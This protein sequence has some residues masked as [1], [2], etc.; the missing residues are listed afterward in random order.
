MAVRIRLKLLGRKKKPFFRVVAIDSK[1]RR[2][3]A[4]LER[5]GWYDPLKT[6]NSFNLKEDRIKHWIAVGAVTSHAVKGVFKKAGLS[7]KWHL[8]K[9]GKSENE[10]E[11][12]LEDWRQRKSKLKTKSVEIPVEEDSTDDEFSEEIKDESIE[13][14]ADEGAVSE[15]ETEEKSE[16]EE[17]IVEKSS[18]E[19]PAED[20]S[21][22]NSS[23]S[24][25]SDSDENPADETSTDND[26][27]EGEK[28]ETVE[29]TS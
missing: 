7:Y 28:V 1:T 26:S 14:S 22:E 4:E 11:Q 2:E 5:L 17:K 12:L 10:I 18:E 8:E 27:D 9:E 20:D 25:N 23:G 24:E 3:G 15:Q 29:E 16:D 6:E 21:K 13:V 19:E